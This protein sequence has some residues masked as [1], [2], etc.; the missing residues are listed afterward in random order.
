MFEPSISPMSVLL[1]VG[2]AQA[3]FLCLVLFRSAHADKAAA[4]SRGCSW[5]LP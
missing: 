4:S 3:F 1:L 2:A 5:C